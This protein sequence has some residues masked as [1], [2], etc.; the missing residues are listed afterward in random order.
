MKKL[1]VICAG[2]IFAAGLA[3]MAAENDFGKF[4]SEAESKAWLAIVAKINSQ[5]RPYHQLIARQMLV[6]ANFAAS[7]LHLN[8]PQ[9]ISLSDIK[10]QFIPSPSYN[11]AANTNYAS[12]VQQLRQG[13]IKANG[14]LDTADYHFELEDG[15]LTIIRRVKEGIVYDGFEHDT[16]FFDSTIPPLLMN[17]NEA[18]QLATQ[19]IGALGMNVSALEKR[20]GLGFQVEQN[21][22]LAVSDDVK[23]QVLAETN[24]LRDFSASLTNKV[25]LPIWTLTWPGG[26]SVQILGTTRELI[27]LKCLAAAIAQRPALILPTVEQ[28]ENFALRQTNLPTMQL[29]SDLLKPPSSNEPHFNPV[30][31]RARPPVSLPPGMVIPK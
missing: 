17:T 4:S 16:R 1:I 21:F 20:H 27:E 13:R 18:Y 11:L 19:W 8:T 28:F 30:L 5:A 15:K 12:P 25:N 26:L 14:W 7:Q 2:I 10:S 29:Q 22:Y 23:N 3:A 31:E 24:R 9:P 6:E